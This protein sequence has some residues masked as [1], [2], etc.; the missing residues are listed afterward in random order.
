MK[1]QDDEIPSALL[2][3]LNFTGI[4]GKIQVAD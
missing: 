4:F 1:G 2:F 3:V